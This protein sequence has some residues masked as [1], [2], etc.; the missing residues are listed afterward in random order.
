M[1]LGYGRQ[2]FPKG[3]STSS[4]PGPHTPNA[5]MAGAVVHHRRLV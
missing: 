2:A 4:G 5:P 1:I 3:P